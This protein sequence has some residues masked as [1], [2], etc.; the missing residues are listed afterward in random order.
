MVASVLVA[1][2]LAA[3]VLVASVLS[4]LRP[5]IENLPT[6]I[7]NLSFGT[8]NMLKVALSKST[9]LQFNVPVGAAQKVVK[10]KIKYI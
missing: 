9:H 4:P 8:H 1:T 6:E 2:V 10:E 5:K 7:V 3:S